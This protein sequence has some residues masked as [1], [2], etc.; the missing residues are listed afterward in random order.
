MISQRRSSQTEHQVYRFI[1][2]SVFALFFLAQPAPARTVLADQ[3]TTLHNLNAEVLVEGD[4]LLF[5]RGGVWEGHIESSTGVVY[6]AYGTGPDPVIKGDSYCILGENV[7]DVTIENLELRGFTSTGIYVVNG[8]DWVIRSNYIKS[9]RAQ[10]YAIWIRTLRP[11]VLSSG[12]V[13]ENNEIGQLGTSYSDSFRV[14]AINLVNTQDVTISGNNI[15]TKFRPAIRT[16]LGAGSTNSR[17]IIIEDNNISDSWGN[18]LIWNTDDALIQNNTIISSAG[19]GIC[20]SFGSSRTRITGNLIHDLGKSGAL[21]NGIDVNGDTSLVNDG[22]ILG[23][24]ISAVNCY[25]V[26]VSS[27]SGWQI[28]HNKLDASENTGDGCNE[29]RL[30]MRV[31]VS[32]IESDYNEFVISGDG[33][34]NLVADELL[35]NKDGQMLMFSEWIS[36]GSQD[37]HSTVS[38]TPMAT[39]TPTPTPRGPTATPTPT[40]RGPTATPTPTP[41]GP[42]AT[43]TPTEGGGSKS[44]IVTVP[45]VA[46][47]DGVGGTP[48]RSDV[49]V[50]NRN[51][52]TQ[53]LRFIYL[54]DEGEK[55]TRIR[56]LQPFST[57]LL[58]NIVK[59]F[60]GGEDGKGPIQIEVLTDGTEPPSVISRTYAARSFGN[61]GSGLPA[62]VEHS[63]GQRRTF[64]RFS[65]ST[66][67]PTVRLATSKHA[68]FL[69][70]AWASGRSMG[71]SQKRRERANR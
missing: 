12:H 8:N 11:N 65:D 23:N 25:S 64:L 43:P 40:P 46:H 57:L 14:G 51:S 50:A 24:S 39:P 22:L 54:P 60:L 41:R 3:A 35:V 17:R 16:M 69:R 53:R 71:S 68:S 7:D 63:T 37:Q 28:V 70:G 45:V 15:H 59:H 48:W 32:Q 44:S 5:E 66:G 34:G 29:R 36:D 67:V 27:V 42:T 26:M 10:R 33:D 56:S 52:I 55:L 6:G 30:A 18:I 9:S 62:D 19:C 38:R 4:R 58:K 21:W 13:I 2:I 1:G 47:I 20:V 61:F 49:A 31:E